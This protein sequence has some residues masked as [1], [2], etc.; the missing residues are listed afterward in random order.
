LSDTTPLVERWEAPFFE[1][2][3]VPESKASLE[4]REALAQAR[5]FQVGREEGLAAG[6]EEAARIVAALEAVAGQMA[7][8]FQALE[9]VVSRELAHLAMQLAGQIVRRELTLDS[10]SVT[11]VMQEALSTLYKLQGEIVIFL[12]PADAGLVAEFAPESLEGKSWKIVEDPEL[13]PGGCQVK[14]P[15]SFVDASVE[16]RLEA[17]FEELLKSFE[18]GMKH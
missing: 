7:Q 18:K 15:T 2:P 12:N 14:T 6:R 3:R 17:V 16:K 11:A 1:E 8:P 9:E 10:S 13:F 5:G 4:E